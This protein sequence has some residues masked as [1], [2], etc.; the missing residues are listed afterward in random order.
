MLAQDFFLALAK[1]IVFARGDSLGVVEE[2]SAKLQVGL[3]FCTEAGV[4]FGCVVVPKRGATE[5]GV[6]TSVSV[7]GEGLLGCAPTA[8]LFGFVDVPK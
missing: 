3:L 7:I 1:E 2:T 5:G 4:V 8:V 6:L